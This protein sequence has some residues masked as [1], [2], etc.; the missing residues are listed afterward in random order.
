MDNKPTMVSLLG[1]EGARQLAGE[2]A[3]QARTALQPLEASGRILEQ[4]IAQVVERRS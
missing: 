3:A 1:L 4:F 2:L